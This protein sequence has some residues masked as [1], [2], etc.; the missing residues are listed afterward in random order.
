M[1]L[2]ATLAALASATLSCAG[3]PTADV[4]AA[5]AGEPTELSCAEPGCGWVLDP[6]ACAAV[7]T[8]L[9]IPGQ[10][11]DVHMTGLQVGDNVL[12]AAGGAY[13]VTLR[14]DA[15]FDWTA[16]RPVS[17]V[18]VTGDQASSSVYSYV[19]P[20]RLDVGLSP[21]N[22]PLAQ[23]LFCSAPAEALAVSLTAGAGFARTWAW[24]I[25]KSSPTSSVTAAVGATVEAQYAVTV[26][27][28]AVDAAWVATG[29]VTVENPLAVAA[30]RVGLEGSVGAV[31]FTPD[32]GDFSGI[33]A[34]GGSVTCTWSAPLGAGLDATA[35]VTVSWGGGGA[36]AATAGSAVRAAATTAR[37]SVVASAPVTFGAPTT[38]VDP[39]VVVTDDRAGTLGTVCADQAPATFSYALPVGPYLTCDASG[40]GYAFSNTASFAAP[41]GASGASTWVVNVQ[42]P[43]SGGCTLT[44]GYWKTHSR[45]GPAPYDARW[46]NLGALEED[47]VFFLSGQTWLEVFRTPVRGSAYYALAHQYMAARLNVLAGASASALGD[48][49]ST[50]EAFFA[51]TAPGASLPAAKRAQLLALADLLDRFNSGL[52]GP[53]HCDDVEPGCAAP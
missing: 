6:G 28:G 13:T 44:Q 12:P 50:A 39:C 8:L 10:F 16:P 29:T 7:A 32:C 38:V 43:C 36:Y 5:A 48:A 46:K 22:P 52:V 2:R 51:A 19:P 4:R 25:D 41:S 34:P 30:S 15:T 3:Q 45:E 11:V 26:E 1:T 14:S 35:V 21:R 33:L 40:E 18:V 47:T 20:A 27:A 23:V 17:F 42:V 37:A 49:L 31:S 9:G 24:S 53:G